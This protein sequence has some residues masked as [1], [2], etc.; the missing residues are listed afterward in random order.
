M[1]NLEELTLFLLIYR[2][3]STYNDGNQ[4]YDQILIHMPRLNKFNFSINTSIYY[5][6]INTT[7]PSNDDIQRSF[8]GRKYQQ[9]GSYADDDLMLSLPRCHIYSLPY[10]FE[11]F[12]FSTNSFQGGIFEKVKWVKITDTRPFEHEFFKIISKSFPFLIQLTVQNYEQQQNKQHSSTFV[13]FPHLLSLHLTGAHDD[14]AE[15]L[16]LKKNTH[17]PCLKRLTI[18]YQSLEIITNHFTNNAIEFNCTELTY[19]S[20]AEPF[21]ARENFHLYFPQ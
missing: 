13:V 17:L 1:S 18:R 3:D 14:Y 7:L 2:Y 9:V 8:I 11:N 12:F 6:Y 19:L 21:V 4:L 10:Q 16:L 15:E 5:T 20:I